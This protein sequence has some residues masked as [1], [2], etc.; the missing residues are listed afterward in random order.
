M[1]KHTGL[2]M[3]LTVFTTFLGFS[4]NL[5]GNIVLIQHFAIASTLA[6]LFNG[7]ITTLVVPPM[8]AKFGQKMGV[9]GPSS[10]LPSIIGFEEMMSSKYGIRNKI[11]ANSSKVGGGK[12]TEF[13]RI[14]TAV[15]S[16][17]VVLARPWAMLFQKFKGDD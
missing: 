1:A 9:A 4:S 13:T 15:S 8:L 14:A 7:V 3:L 17:T 5:F 12:V 11:R 2:P 10:G 6:I 16:F